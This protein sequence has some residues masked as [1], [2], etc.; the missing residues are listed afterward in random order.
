MKIKDVKI[1]VIRRE[2][3]EFGEVKTTSTP[4]SLVRQG[5]GE[6]PIITI[7][8]DDGIEGTSFGTDGLLQAQYLDLVK[9]MLLGKDPLY[10]EKIW[11]EIWPVTSWAGRF[12]ATVLG[13]VDIAIWD[14]V[15]KAAN[16]PIYKLLGAYRDKVAAY[17][18]LM[19]S[20]PKWPVE[21]YAKNAVECKARGFTA[22]K[23]H[24]SKT[25]FGSP[26]EDLNEHVA[27][28]RGVRE[29][30]GDDMVLMY[31]PSTRYDR[32]QALKVGRELEKL[33]FYWFEEPIKLTDVDGLIHLCR[34]LDIP[35][36]ALEVLPGNIYTRAQ[37]I[38][39]GAVDIVQ[40]DTL[41]NGGITPLKKTAS[42]AEALGMN[43]EIHFCSNP[44]A[45]AANLHVMCSIKN[46]S[47]FEWVVPDG[48][49]YQFGLKEGIKLDDEGYVHVPEGP[50]LGL[51]VD[52]EYVDNHTIA[53][54]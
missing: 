18:S 42:L 27:I 1:Q 4:G 44:L 24:I 53:T 19:P 36:A 5:R 9:P 35:I 7:I 31:D 45:N 51:E 41:V 48:G 20:G 54:L 39:R 23:L 11:Q 28:C 6:I 21:A 2:D 25:W 8:T 15:G 26:N 32:N 43:C 10:P 49:R 40:S 30:V 3:K 34:S 38:T 22:Y 12:P 14:I 37:Y 50:G 46:C 29:A 17:A 47:F 16:L 13:T 52:W 33:D